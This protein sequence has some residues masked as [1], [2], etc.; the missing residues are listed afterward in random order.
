M[1]EWV[2]LKRV[3]SST[4]FFEMNREEIIRKVKAL[5]EEV[6]ENTDLSLEDI[7]LLG[8][9]GRLTLRVIIDSPKGISINDCERVSR[10][11]EALLD[12][13]DPIPGSYT[14]EVSSPGLDRPLRKIEDFIRFSGRL[15]R[16]TT[17]EKV[18]N[19]TFFIGRIRAVEKDTVHLEVKGRLLK[20]PFHIIKK[21]N[22]EVE[23]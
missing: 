12:I 22:L 11:L 4:L 3:D 19:Q 15:A 6:L 13:E 5:V 9:P 2:G 17:S 16:V 21:A 8:S 20:I 23:F 10:Q 14:L 1:S 7:E 18:A